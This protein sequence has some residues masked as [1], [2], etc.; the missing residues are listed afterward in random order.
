[1]LGLARALGSNGPAKAFR[2]A[3]LNGGGH[4]APVF[5]GDPIYAWSEVLERLE[6]PGRRDVG[7]LR[8]RTGAAK[9]HPCG[10]FPGRDAGGAYHP[11]V[12]LDLDY[13]VLIKRR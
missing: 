5:A 4:V 8:L 13:T 9:N 11:A 6:L 1:V 2:A 3:A 7:A 10:D 12:V